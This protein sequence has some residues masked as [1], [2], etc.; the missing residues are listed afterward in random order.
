MTK[1]HPGDDTHLLRVN[2]N[3]IFPEY[4]STE[5]RAALKKPD[6]FA[7]NYMLGNAMEFVNDYYDLTYD[8]YQPVDPLGPPPHNSNVSIVCK[9][10]MFKWVLPL[11]QL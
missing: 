5:R 4:S 1:Y 6:G 7:F 11:M 2:M 9:E 10:P 3:G 8:Y